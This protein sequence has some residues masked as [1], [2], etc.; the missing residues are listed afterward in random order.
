MK[1]QKITN[2][3]Y[4]GVIAPLIQKFYNRVKESSGLYEGVTYESLYTYLARLIQF[5]KGKTEDMSEVWV[6][7]DEDESP[8]G[9]SAWQVMDIPHV[10]KVFCPILYND[11]RNQAAIKELYEEF[12]QF[13]RRHRAPLY[14]Y[15]AVNEKT[16]NYFSGV[17]GKMGVEF[18]ETGLREY[19]GREV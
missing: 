16:G 2:P 7:Y 5:G 12:K 18:K 4:L 19:I 9:F 15:Y 1:I 11:T 3:V 13:G 10:G 6:A 14:Q 8:V 17:A